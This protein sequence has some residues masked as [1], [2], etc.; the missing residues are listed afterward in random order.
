MVNCCKSFDFKLFFVYTLKLLRIPIWHF[1]HNFCFILTDIRL[2]SELN[3][4]GSK[5]SFL[6]K[7]MQRLW[8]KR[9]KG[10]PRRSFLSPLLISIPIIAAISIY[11]LIVLL[12]TAILKISLL[13][14]DLFCK[15]CYLFPTFKMFWAVVSNLGFCPRPR[16]SNVFLCFWIFLLKIWSF[17][18]VMRSGDLRSYFKYRLSLPCFINAP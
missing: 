12:W 8:A 9:S 6:T 15:L 1:A 11:C 10:G 17:W 14:I 7:Q 13:H 2:A 18:N 3:K 5:V 16:F 4:Y